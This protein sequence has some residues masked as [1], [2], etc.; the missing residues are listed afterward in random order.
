MLWQTQGFVEESPARLVRLTTPAANETLVLCDRADLPIV[1]QQAV[2]HGADLATMVGLDLRPVGKAFAVEFVFALPAFD[3]FIRVRAGIPVEEPAYPAVTP[4]V[5]AAQW[6]EREAKDLFGIEPIGHPDPRR[7]VLHDRWPRGFH[8]LRKDVSPNAQP[9]SQVRHYDYFRAHG[10]GVHEL[11]VGPIHAGIIE[12]GHF[13]FSTI[14]ELVLHLDAR[15]FYTHRGVEK[16]V[17]GQSFAR[18]LYTVERTCGVCTVSHAI[19]F[20]TAVERIAQASVPPRA[21]WLRTLLLELERLYNHVGDIGNICAGA[22][23]H[24]GSSRGAILKECLQRLNE[25][26]AG[27]RFLMGVVGIGGLRY[28]L[29][30]AVLTAASRELKSLRAEA[31]AYLEML[32]ETAS[33][34]ARIRGSGRI[35]ADTVRALGGTGVAAR[36]AGLAT[37]YR[38]SHPHLAYAALKPDLQ[39][40]E[41]GDVGARLR[42]RARE[43]LQSFDL[44][45]EILDRVPSGPVATAI[46]PVMPGASALGYAEGPRGANVHWLMVDRENR[47]YRLHI[48]SSSFANWP[49]VPRA[50]AGNIVPDFPLIN[51]SFELCYACCDR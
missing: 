31:V 19:A 23:F 6:S 38:G 2:A 28:D 41:E 35:D 22:G 34:Q 11:A 13:R 26:I 40:E 20:S 5:P 3:E 8:P 45:L 42:V 7:L 43:A 37:D 9:Q 15:L 36:A 33:F 46:G 49:L 16:I 47:V 32:G 24:A 21:L 14:G 27:H 12:P 51:K 50:V 4:I 30:Q 18:A 10:E 1:A 29:D 44:T 39:Y 17:E 25:R 48:R